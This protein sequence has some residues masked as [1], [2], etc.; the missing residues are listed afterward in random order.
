MKTFEVYDNGI[1]KIAVK[2]GLSWPGA[3]F[4]IIWTLWKKLW[5]I[6]ILII[7]SEVFMTILGVASELSDREILMACR[8]VGFCWTVYLLFRG[9][10]HLKSKLVNHGYR[11]VNIVVAPNAETAISQTVF[12]RQQ[13][14][15]V[16]IGV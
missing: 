11:L 10:H 7:M 8:F 12:S 14:P 6:S 5:L 4:G 9:N 3:F 13:N 15:V 16:Q 2:K 1:Q